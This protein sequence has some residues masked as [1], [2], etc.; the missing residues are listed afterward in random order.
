MNEALGHE[1]L[2]LVLHDKYLPLL[3]F[4][5][6]LRSARFKEANNFMFCSWLT[7]YM[8][9]F[10][11]VKSSRSSKFNHSNEGHA[12]WKEPELLNVTH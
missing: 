9:L 6:M 10:V 8:F 12:I 4:T 7:L 11:K 1:G 2:T 3:S 5:G